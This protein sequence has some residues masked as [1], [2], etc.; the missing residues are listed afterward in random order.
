M[1]G[2]IGPKGPAHVFK[3]TRMAGR[4]GGDRVTVKN[5]EVAAIDEEKNLIYVKG[6]VPG[7]INSYV[8]ISAQGELQVNLKKT[9]APEVPVEEKKEAPL[10]EETPVVSEESVT[11]ASEEVSADAGEVSEEA[12]AKE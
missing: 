2:S 11:P 9:V 3:G 6:A 7:A 1:P 5:L 8:F 4:M 12:P 10:V